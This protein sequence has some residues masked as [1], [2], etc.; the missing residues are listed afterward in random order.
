MSAEDIKK[1]AYVE[2][3]RNMLVETTIKEPD[4]VFYDARKRPF[5]LYGF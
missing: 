4:V 3:D 2:V 1:E 5:E